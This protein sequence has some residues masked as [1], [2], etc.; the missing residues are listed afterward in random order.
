MLNQQLQIWKQKNI[1]SIT[2]CSGP[3]III[4]QQIKAASAEP[5][6]LDDQ[7]W[8][9]S[10]RETGL[11]IPTQKTRSGGQTRAAALSWT[12]PPREEPLWT[13]PG[14]SGTEPSRSGPN[15][16]WNT[17]LNPDEMFKMEELTTNLDE[18]HE[19]ISEI[20]G[21]DQNKQQFTIQNQ[22]F[23]KIQF[24]VKGPVSCKIN[25]IIFPSF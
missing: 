24:T 2:T 3:W 22:N 15:T 6:Q 23:L 7:V 10:S 21:S 9:T 1:S 4:Q 25:V 17:A 5:L 16:S 20:F 13:E 11:W 18:K 8:P 12:N 19:I 14:P